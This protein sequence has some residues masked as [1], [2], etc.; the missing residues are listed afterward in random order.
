MA[1]S[2]SHVESAS[3]PNRLGRS[4]SIAVAASVLAL[5]ALA[6]PG[7][8]VQAA[9]PSKA[10]SRSLTLVIPSMASPLAT[11]QLLRALNELVARSPMTLTAAIETQVQHSGGSAGVSLM[12]IGGTTPFEWSF[13]GDEVFT[14]NGIATIRDIA[15]LLALSPD[16]YTLLWQELRIDQ[17]PI[18][19]VP[20]PL[21]RFAIVW[22]HLP[23]DDDLIARVMGL[24][25]S[26]KV[27]NLRMVAKTHL[28]KTLAAK[29]I[30]AGG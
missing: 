24:E 17:P 1:Q 7:N 4:A 14:A 20:D 5:I 16:H 18:D 13:D 21:M 23:L 3:R 11:P 9:G 27:I 26:Q 8:E 22:K 30:G 12:E 15:E 10:S 28:A 6:P 25:S 2:L 29:K 19:A